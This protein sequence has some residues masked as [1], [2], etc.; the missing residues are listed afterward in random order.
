MVG[1]GDGCLAHGADGKDLKIWLLIFI[2]AEC[3]LKRL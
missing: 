2:D 1:C 3:L